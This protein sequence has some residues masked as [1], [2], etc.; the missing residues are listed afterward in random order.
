M[1]Q[2]FSDFYSWILDCV[3]L[4]ETSCSASFRASSNIS[5]SHPDQCVCVLCKA[6]I[7]LA[8]KRVW[9]QCCRLSEIKFKTLS[10]AVFTSVTRSGGKQRQTVI[11]HLRQA[12]NLSQRFG[13]SFPVFRRGNRVYGEGDKKDRMEEETKTHI[14]IHKNDSCL[15]EFLHN[16]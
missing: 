14:M 7:G 2:S 12:G 5:S 8:L 10:S 3:T 4:Q 15:C 11:I 1:W 9:F 13:G 16:H 6:A